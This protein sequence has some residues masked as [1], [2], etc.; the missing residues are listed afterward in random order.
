M[1][2][3]LLMLQWLKVFYVNILDIPENNRT[4]EQREQAHI[5]NAL[6][7]WYYKIVKWKIIIWDFD[8]NR[9]IETFGKRIYDIETLW[10]DAKEYEKVC[11]SRENGFDSLDK[12]IYHA[13]ECKISV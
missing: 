8:R 2:P 10:N 3:D 12:W 13:N 5:R 9:N 7:H 11:H 4:L 6:I 1:L